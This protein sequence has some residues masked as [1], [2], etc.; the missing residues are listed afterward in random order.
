MNKIFSSRLSS[1]CFRNF[2]G[3]FV[4][5]GLLTSL[6]PASVFVPQAAASDLQK[7]LQGVAGALTGGGETQKDSGSDTRADVHPL[8][9]D[10]LKEALSVGI[11]EAVKLVSAPDGYF[12]NDLIR[13]PLPD[14]LKKADGLIRGIGGGVLSD[15]LIEK[16]NRAAEAAAPRATDIFLSAIKGM[17]IEDAAGL[18]TG[19]DT[20]ATDYLKEKTGDT[21][22]ESF[23]PDVDASMKEIGAVAAFDDYIGKYADNP[24][25]SAV[26]PE[27]DISRYVTGKAV[28]GLFVMVAGE[29][30]RIR[31]DPAARITDLLKDVFGGK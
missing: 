15:A 9:A 21:L 10:G 16:M 30:E 11:Q 24:L 26:L 12:K 20:A 18:M 29:E 2:R 22:V 8:A 27:T 6:L 19:G 25:V 7:T 5:I 13:I 14:S 4:S 17:S 23:F 28:D 31:R 1:P 3:V